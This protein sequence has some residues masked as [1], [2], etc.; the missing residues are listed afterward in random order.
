MINKEASQQL[1]EELLH[2][3]L[4][5]ISCFFSFQVYIPE[6]TWYTNLLD[7]QELIQLFAVETEGLTLI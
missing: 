6:H 2:S 3:K 7:F 4:I 1:F 5:T